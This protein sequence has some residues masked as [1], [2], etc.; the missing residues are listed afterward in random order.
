MTCGFLKYGR[1]AYSGVDNGGCG[2][3]LQSLKTLDVWCLYSPVEYRA[4]FSIPN[5]DIGTI[6]VWDTSHTVLH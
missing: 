2:L 6:P 5:M 4:T 3:A 1:L